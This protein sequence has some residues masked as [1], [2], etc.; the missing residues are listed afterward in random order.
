MAQESIAHYQVLEKIGEGGMGAVYKA[1]DTH[2]QRVVALKVLPDDKV[3]DLDRRRRFIQEARAASSLNH[4]NIITVHDADVDAGIHFIAM[5]YVDGATLRRTIG[6][7][8]LP[9]KQLLEYA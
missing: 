2:L 9:L 8:G 3:S 5:E 6:G 1:L 7:H 4:P